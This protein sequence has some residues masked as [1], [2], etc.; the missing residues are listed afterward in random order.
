[1]LLKTS[2]IIGEMNT[3]YIAGKTSEGT[4]INGNR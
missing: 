4:E 2:Q 3:F 1:M